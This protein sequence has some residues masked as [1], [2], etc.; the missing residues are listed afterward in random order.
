MA[1]IINSSSS[2][3]K[4]IGFP[5]IKG[6]EQLDMFLNQH[7]NKRNW[8]LINDYVCGG[9]A[10]FSHE[11]IDLIL[12]FYNKYQIPL[13]LIYTSKMMLG[14]LDLL[15]KGYFPK[16]SDILAIHTGG[17]QG[18]RGMNQRFGLDIPQ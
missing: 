5:A 18:N 14:I 17:L 13:D 7:T 12:D 2:N 15:K 9:Y 4:L 10:K 8:R 6:A 1:G 16:G 11:L 3:Q